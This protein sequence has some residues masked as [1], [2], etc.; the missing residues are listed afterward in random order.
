[1]Q[2]IGGAQK[3]RP[4][5]SIFVY[6]FPSYVLCPRPDRNSVLELSHTKVCHRFRYAIYYL[7]KITHKNKWNIIWLFKVL[8]A[9]VGKLSWIFV[10]CFFLFGHLPSLFIPICKHFLSLHAWHWFLCALSTIHLP[11]PAWHLKNISK[12]EKWCCLNLCLSSRQFI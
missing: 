4:W 12:K 10:C 2:K 5:K 1:M 11:V 6:L 8:C 3:V 9:I 7:T